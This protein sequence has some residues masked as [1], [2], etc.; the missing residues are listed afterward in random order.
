MLTKEKLTA[1]VCV[2]GG[3][4]AGI[5]AAIAA[6]RCGADTV[7]M[8]DRP[9]PGGNA[10]SECRVHIG[11]ASASGT[12]S[13]ARE[14]GILEALQ[15]KNLAVNPQ[16]SYSVW[17]TI[18]FEALRY[19]P[20]LRILFNCSCY[21]ARMDGNR[22]VSATGLQLTTQKHVEVAA[23]FF[24]DCS[25]DGVM[26]PLTG[27]ETRRGREG[28]DEFG[29]S[30]A[31]EHADDKTMGMT[32]L[33]FGRETDR[34]QPFHPPEWAYTFKSIDDLPYRLP[35]NLECGYWWIELGG[36]GDS[37]ADT[38][39]VRDELLRLVYGIWDHLKNHGDYGADN[40]ALDW[41]QFLP[42]KRESR[43]LMGDHILCQSDVQTGG[44][45]PD[46]VAY[47]GWPLDRHPPGGFWAKAEPADFGKV[48]DIYGIPLR[49]LYSRNVG[50]LWMAGRN[51]SCT[52]VGMSST[53]LMGTC[54][55][56]GQAVG[57]AAVYALQKG[58]SPREC[59]SG[60]ALEAVQQK[61]LAGDCYL[62]GYARRFARETLE[63][64]LSASAGTPEPLRD[65]I[66]RQVHD[67]DHSWH[68]SPGDWVEYRW[69]QPTPISSVTVAF[70]SDLN[71]EICLTH[72]V[73]REH[74]LPD[75]LVKGFRL[76][77]EIDGAWR[78]VFRDDDNYLRFREIS[79]EGLAA[80][81]LRLVPE[82]TRGAES[83]RIF[84]FAVNEPPP[85]VF[86]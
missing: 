11:G 53:R 86:A 35:G 47:G 27:A 7:L 45:F 56:M 46:A 62:P 55:L 28:R 73:K 58:L 43:R 63:A 17:D 74:T 37:I 66:N 33:F 64:Q 2:I 6:A 16:R 82:S 29:E 52:H 8:H 84:T 32:C 18:M 38:E 75:T 10:S 49:S 42:A 60:G 12:R 72:H 25:G 54:A 40:W 71:T 5:C 36:E 80:T 68:G 65:G 57:T 81:A 85:N 50:N 59:A 1:D 77:A 20:G 19:Q 48:P 3:G 9:V 4:M 76:D 23:G 61:L 79:L 22:I 69:S 31:P 39:H 30:L 41:V 70:D 14:T 13:N 15:L 26:A 24:V 83:V 78:E 44:R 51:A 21:S 67:A 34:P